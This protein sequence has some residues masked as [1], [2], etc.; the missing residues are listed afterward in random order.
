MNPKISQYIL[1]I[2]NCL[3]YVLAPTCIHYCATAHEFGLNNIFLVI[4]DFLFTINV[5]F[6]CYNP[7]VSI[8]IFSPASSTNKSFR[9]VTFNK[10][11][12][13]CEFRF[14]GKGTTCHERQVPSGYQIYNITYCVSSSELYFFNYCNQLIRACIV[15]KFCRNIFEICNICSENEPVSIRVKPHVR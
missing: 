3:L 13:D 15:C 11:L 8:T 12:D 6:T 5:V 14:I 4:W 10:F 7:R 9:T 1:Y 2:W